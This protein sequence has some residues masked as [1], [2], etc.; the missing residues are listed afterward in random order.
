MKSPKHHGAGLG[1]N[2]VD[3]NKKSEAPIRIT[4]PDQRFSIAG[5]ALVKAPPTDAWVL[6][7]AGALLLGV[8][9]MSHLDLRVV[10]VRRGRIG[11]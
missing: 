1:L 4:R 10:G 9:G 7:L 5:E 3:S 8:Q 2:Q 11:A 6:S